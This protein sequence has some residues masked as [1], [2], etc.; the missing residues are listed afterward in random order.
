MQKKIQLASLMLTIGLSV[1][2]VKADE[3][4]AKRWLKTEFTDSTLTQEQQLQEMRWF[5]DA[6]KP[7]AGMNINVASETIAT[8]EYEYKVLVKA[9]SEI[10]G[11]NITH[12]LIQEG[13]VVEN[14]KLKCNQVEIYMTPM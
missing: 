3:D 1:Q 2:S 6:S 11:I 9:F 5:I 12:D 8:H 14:F 13:D 7:F 10:T 4:A